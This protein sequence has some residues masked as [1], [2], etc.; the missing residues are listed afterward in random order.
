MINE[1]FLD[2]NGKQFTN[3]AEAEEYADAIEASGG[4]VAVLLCPRPVAAVRL[5]DRTSLWPAHRK[6]PVAYLPGSRKW[7][8]E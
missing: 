7:R 4:I 2:V 1:P 5:Q 8:K 6:P 3:K